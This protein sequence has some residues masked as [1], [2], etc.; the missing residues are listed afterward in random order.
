MRENKKVLI[1][2][3]AG[4]I[5]S[6]TVKL[7]QEKSYIP[8][9]IDNLSTGHKKSLAE[10][11]IFYE[12]DIS[13]TNLVANIVNE[14]KP[15][16]VIH[17]A[18][19]I[20]AGVS[21]YEPASFYENNVSKSIIFFNTIIKHGLK[22][23][24]FS[25]SA[26]VYGIPNQLPITEETETNPCNTYGRTKLMLE[27]VLYDYARAYGTESIILRYFNACGAHPSGLIGEAHL[28]KTHLIERAILTALGV[29]P[30]MLIFGTDYPTKDGSAI[31]DY[32][33]VQDLAKAHFCALNEIT[34]GSMNS[35]KLIKTYN[36]G[37]GKGFSVL[38][39]IKTV[40]EISGIKIK[41]VFSKKRDGD[42]PELIASSDKIYKEIGFVPEY[43]TIE[44]MVETAW[45]WHKSNRMG[46]V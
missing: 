11:T 1:T 17:F 39:V 18:A 42:P 40:E 34:L 7:L 33:H 10:H 19:S 6:H 27:Q 26:G 23:F 5:G 28:H 45:N 25:S 30:E 29:Y 44:S 35:E 31:R 38:E 43:Q 24:I 13:D 8:V 4:Y 15:V 37:L 16:S 22:K 3:G 46:Y 36:I 41:K 21:M 20:E 2:G 9:V 12:G 14:H 32:I